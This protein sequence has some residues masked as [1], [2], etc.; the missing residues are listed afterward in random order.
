MK[1]ASALREAVWAK[2][3]AIHLAVPG[4]DYRAHATD[5]LARAEAALALYAERHGSLVTSLAP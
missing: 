1:V 5:Y 2:V 3:S 4:A